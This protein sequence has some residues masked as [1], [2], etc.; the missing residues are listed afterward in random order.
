MKY[1]LVFLFSLL[2]LSACSTKEVYKPKVVGDDWEKYASLPE[3][4]VDVSSNIALLEDRSVLSTEKHIEVEIPESQ[5]VISKSKEWIISAAIDGNMTL[6]S[7][8]DKTLQEHFDLKK[9]VASANVEGNNLAVLFADNEMALYNIESKAALFKEQGSSASVADSRVVPPLFMKGLVLYATLDGKVV[10]VNIEQKKRLRT[11]IVSSEDTFNNIIYADVF[12]NKIIAATPYKLL[13]MSQKE[14]RAK[15]EVRNLAF[16]KE[17][18]YITTK[19]G[20]LVSLTSDLQVESKIKFPFAHFLGMVALD[21]KLYIL[22]KEGYMIV[23]DAK[24]F[25]YSV[26]EVDLDDGFIF[27]GDKLFYVS[28]EKILIE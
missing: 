20:E 4:I 23:V 19:Q 5:R 1:Y 16:G 22:E 7:I 10:I 8:N 6:T 26:H 27:I 28:D 3:E 12:D 25:D 17:L 15:Y 14:I 18:I 21:D 9:T 11:V 24:S 13:S 2:F